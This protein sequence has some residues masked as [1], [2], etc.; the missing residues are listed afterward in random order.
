MLMS[1]AQCSWL[2]LLFVAGPAA[3]AGQ[4]HGGGH[5]RADQGGVQLP[6]AAVPP[7]RTRIT[8]KR[9][10][11]IVRIIY[12]TVLFRLQCGPRTYG[13]K[14]GI[15]GIVGI[16]IAQSR[17]EEGA[18]EESGTEQSGVEQS[19]VEQSGVEQSGVE[20]SGAER[21]RAERSGHNVR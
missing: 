5:V 16:I 12:E 9:T 19:G 2:C 7:V 3:G 15:V 10:Q 18:V 6:A 17:V 11:N 4:V 1:H 8:G 21:G 14:G 13:G 20:Q